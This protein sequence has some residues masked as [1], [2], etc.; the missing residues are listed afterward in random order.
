MLNQKEDKFNPSFAE[1]VGRD[2]ET[3]PPASSVAT[4]HPPTA[5]DPSDGGGGQESA[6]EGS[7]SHVGAIVGGVVGGVVGLA[8]IAVIVFFLR[9]RRRRT[10]QA[11]VIDLGPDMGAEWE[12]IEMQSAHK[13]QRLYDPSDPST[14]PAPISVTGEGYTPP[15]AYNGKYTG[16]AEI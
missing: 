11:H 4:N 6:D 7:T 5:T 10:E 12:T 16:S 1:S 15:Q 13:T 2:P 3:T 14:F 8:I 9:K